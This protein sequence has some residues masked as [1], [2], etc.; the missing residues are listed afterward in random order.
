VTQGR[1][2][3]FTLR[4]GGNRTLKG[5]IKQAEGHAV[6]CRIE[7]GVYITITENIRRPINIL[8]RTIEFDV[9]QIEKLEGF[10]L[11]ITDLIDRNKKKVNPHYLRLGI[12]IYRDRNGEIL[13]IRIK[14]RV[15]RL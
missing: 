3:I 13:E 10:R 6:M 14:P 11:T 1:P 12:I 15:S 8:N 5:S 7:R 4:E 9:R 2:I